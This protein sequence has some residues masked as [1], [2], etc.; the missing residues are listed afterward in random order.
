MHPVRDI[1][2][3]STFLSVTHPSFSFCVQNETLTHSVKKTP[4]RETFK[5]FSSSFSW[6]GSTDS[7]EST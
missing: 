3:S 6:V 4:G 5:G 7:P 1:P 2:R